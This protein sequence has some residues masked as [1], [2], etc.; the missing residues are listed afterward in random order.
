MHADL[1]HLRRR[2]SSERGIALPVV[3]GVMSVLLLLIVVAAGDSGQAN[4]SANQDRRST[5]AL[6]G[7]DAALETAVYRLNTLDVTNQPASGKCVGVNASNQAVL[8]GYAAGGSWCP[9]VDG[10]LADGT[11]YRYWVSAETPM[12]GGGGVTRTVVAQ[13][14]DGGV[15]RRASVQLSALSQGTPLFGTGTIISLQQF[16]IGGDTRVFGNVQSNGN[17]RLDGS[18]QVCG[19]ATPGPG[20]TATRTGGASYQCGGSLT[21]ATAPVTLPPVDLAP[22]ANNDNARICASS[23]PATSDPCSEAVS[24]KVNWEPAKRRLDVQGDSHI[25]LGGNVYFFCYFRVTNGARVIIAP[26]NPGTP[27]RIY[28]DTPQNCANSN[29]R[30]RFEVIN[31]GKIENPYG[32]PALQFY[33]AGDSANP[34]A[35]AQEIAL[36]N[37][38]TINMPMLVYA[39]NSNVRVSG[40]VQVTGA[41]AARQVFVEGSAKILS[42]PDSGTVTVG[43]GVTSMLQPGVYREC[44]VTGATA[45]NPGAG[46]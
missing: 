2:L 34:G 8:Q 21:P 25:T 37:S 33:V 18:A 40:V 29:P 16:I 3:M 43:G 38:G 44:A 31:N 39:P 26:R 45:A 28:I 32:A 35:S 11:S 22:A 13:S 27:V 20:R 12:V 41:V 24:W 23:N 4:D 36:A 5:R 6:Q 42:H 19:N 1:R 30:G 7:A 46:C 15:M 14:N 10:L 9:P 17:I